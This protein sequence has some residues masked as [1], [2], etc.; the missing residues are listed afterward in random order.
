MVQP[1]KITA[2]KEQILQQQL[3][4]ARLEHEQKMES[5]RIEHEKRMLHSAEEH[6]LKV[7]ILEAELKAKQT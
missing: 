2:L 3:D 4:Q 6:K 5:I 7:Q 1:S